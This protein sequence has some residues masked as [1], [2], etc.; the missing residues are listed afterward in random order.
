MENYQGISERLHCI[1]TQGFEFIMPGKCPMQV[2]YCMVNSKEVSEGGKHT[3]IATDN[4]S[5]FPP[6]AF[7]LLWPTPDPYED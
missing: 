1:Q 2:W 5:I 4:R 3:W 6:I 7:V